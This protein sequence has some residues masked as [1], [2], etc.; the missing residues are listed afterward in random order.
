[1]AASV[2]AALIQGEN[3]GG[4]W[5]IDPVHFAERH[6]LFMII[7][8]GEILVAVGAKSYLLV[9][10]QGMNL[11]LAAVV[12]I[13][14]SMACAYWWS[15]FAYIPRL[16]EN[17]LASVTGRKRAERARDVGSLSH[18]PVV[19]GLILY[20]VVAK[21]VL[22]HPFAPMEISDR[23][24]LLG[25][26]LGV[27][28]GFI[29]AQVYMARTLNRPRLVTL[30]IAAAWIVVSRALPAIAVVA[31]MSVLL[32]AVS[33]YLWRRVRVSMAHVINR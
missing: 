3:A 15:Y 2:A 33:T 30:A 12:L 7:C 27:Y 10:D 9:G 13:T 32:I 21:H 8:L 4:Q 16:F 20:A 17:S 25:S 24:M 22:E 18:F 6:A 28:G 31:G 11:K 23:T 19:L 26:L 29:T 1:M 14:V 5:D